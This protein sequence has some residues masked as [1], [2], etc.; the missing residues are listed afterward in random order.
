MRTKR[1]AGASVVLTG[2]LLLTACGGGDG[3]S[4]DASAEEGGGSFSVYIGEPE[5][6]LIP[7]NTNETE[8]GQIVDALWTGL[9]EYDRET[10]EA[11]YT[12][13][14]ESIESEDQK[15]WTVNLKDGW[16]FHDGTP[17]TAQ[18]YVDTWNYVANSENAQGN[19]Y[20]FANVEGYEDLQAEEGKKP[21]ATEMSGL[22]VID[23]QTFEVTLTDPYAQ[24]PTTVG[25]TAFFP[26][27]QAFFDDPEGFGAQPIGNGPFKADEAFQD[28]VGIN[29]TRYDEFGGEE[30]AKS[31][32][33]EFRVYTEINTAYNDLQA[34]SLDV[35]DELPPDAIASA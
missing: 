34:G 33:V 6:P 25:Y 27:P 11:A 5:N 21:A 7:G 18:S 22:R 20:F 30:P 4:G 15:T 9:V 29:L 16:T 31:E 17:V 14:A 26:L 23:D 8:G 12:G 1:I 35:M 19:S 2:S 10:N 3:G 24:W 32:G 28:G 13:V